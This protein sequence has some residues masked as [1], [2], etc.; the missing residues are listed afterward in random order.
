M[1]RILIER[2]G[3]VEHFSINDEQIHRLDAD[4]EQQRLV[5]VMYGQIFAKARHGQ[6]RDAI[7]AS[8]SVKQCALRRVAQ[9]HG[10]ICCNALSSWGAAAYIRITIPRKTAICIGSTRPLSS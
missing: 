3:V 1:A 5:N 8:P 7:V 2:K 4:V 9:R 6:A 10:Q